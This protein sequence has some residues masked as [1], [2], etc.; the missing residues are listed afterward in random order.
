MLLFDPDARGESIDLFRREDQRAGGMRYVLLLRRPMKYF[1]MAVVE[2]LSS[3]K[4]TNP[5]RSISDFPQFNA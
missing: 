3:V 4:A 5:V 1:M 2:I